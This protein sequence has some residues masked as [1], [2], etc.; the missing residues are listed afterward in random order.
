M[1]LEGKVMLVTG[2]GTGIGR[3]LAEVLVQRGARVAIAGR[4]LHKL[5]ETLAALPAES[6]A[7]ALQ[8]DM[9]DWSSVKGLARSLLERFGHVDAVV[10][11]AAVGFAGA[12]ED[13]RPEEMDYLLK[14]DLVGPMWLTKLLLPSLRERPEAML[15]NVCSLAGLV[16]IPNQSLYCAAKHG[17]RGFSE[18]LRRELLDSR[19]RVLTVYPGGVESE[20]MSDAVRA[21]MAEQR[22]RMFDM[23]R[24]HDAAEQIAQAMER[25]G[26]RVLVANA[27]EK[28]L[29]RLNRLL[30]ALVDRRMRAMSAKIRSIVDL[31]TADARARSPLQSLD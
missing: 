30:P 29:V 9:S 31:A 8:A 17:L 5:E 25:D 10:N 3:A 19:V 23:M 28:N 21:K 16:A 18:A 7:V 11:N 26:S 1:R 15:V 14:V 27:M 6:G 24:A 20:L 22:F 2:G 13:L 12:L 4:R